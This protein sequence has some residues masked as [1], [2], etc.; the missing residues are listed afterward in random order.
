MPEP[1]RVSYGPRRVLYPQITSMR[2][3]EMSLGADTALIRGRNL[4]DEVVEFV[5]DLAIW[6]LTEA[7]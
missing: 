7:D 3:D 4:V 1:A 5:E 2:E 6:L